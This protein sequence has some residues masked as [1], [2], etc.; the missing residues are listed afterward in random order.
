MFTELR[1][2]NFQGFGDLEKIRLAPLTLIFGPNSSGKSSIIRS[3]L[4][5]KQSM[6]SR[7]SDEGRFSFVDADADL[8]G[9]ANVVHKHDISAEIQIGLSMARSSRIAP[10]ISKLDVFVPYG[11]A[12]NRILLGGEVFSGNDR[13]LGDFLGT[14]EIEFVQDESNPE[15][16]KTGDGFIVGPDAL[17]AQLKKYQE[18]LVSRVDSEIDALSGYD[19]HAE[20]PYL[21]DDLEFMNF[22]R[23]GLFVGVDGARAA[24]LRNDTGVELDEERVKRKF[25]RLVD[26]LITSPSRILD[27]RMRRLVHL[28]GL[29]AIPSRVTSVGST[30]NT[31]LADA[32][33]I[34][35]ILSSNDRIMNLASKLLSRLTQDQYELRLARISANTV[36]F[37][38]SIGS[39]ALFDKRL[40]TMTTFRDVGVG[41][42]QVLPIITALAQASIPP[43]R[44]RNGVPLLTGQS[45]A[46]VLIEQP[47][48]HLHPRMQGE[49]ADVIIEA[50]RA[51]SGSGPQVIME[52]HSEN[53]ILRV[54]RRIREG[55][56]RA[57]DVSVIFVDKDKKTGQ[58]VANELILDDNGEFLTSWPDSFAVMRLDEILP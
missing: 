23:R 22:V 41:L 27:S 37:L 53:I 54:Q 51:K 29:R 31:L 35:A 25:Q 30:E 13:D 33:N 36:E 47:E 49:L 1:L 42:S 18:L 32:S 5:L 4:L 26:E 38:G 52:T 40:E 9:F 12:V 55:S 11:D 58:S 39:L 8:G 16:F 44:P 43:T 6:R 15:A 57:Q 2:A 10:G 19:V 34:V 50:S 20:E 21:W 28:A 24:S 46:T 7:T 56:I 45:I 17:L 48:L 14:Y 3:L